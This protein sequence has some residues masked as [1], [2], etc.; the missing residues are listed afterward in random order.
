MR[1]DDIKKEFLLILLLL[2]LMYILMG[3]AQ[4]QVYAG[5]GL[6]VNTQVSGSDSWE[7]GDSMGG[8]F[9]IGYRGKV[10]D[11]F[12]AGVR[13]IHVSHPFV[14]APF[15]NDSEDSVDHAGIYG[16]YILWTTGEN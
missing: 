12:N 2:L 4:P 14:G 15:D 9:E 8:T 3:C 6:G 16:E 13:W 5:I 1:K 10:S 11:Q 7:D